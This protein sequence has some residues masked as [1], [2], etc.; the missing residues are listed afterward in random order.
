[1]DGFVAA[2]VI[3]RHT[4]EPYHHTMYRLNRSTRISP[5]DKSP[6]ELCASDSRRP[7]SQPRYSSF[8]FAARTTRDFMT[9]FLHT[10]PI[11]H[12][13]PRTHRAVS[14]TYP[15]SY[16]ILFTG[17]CTGR[18]SLPREFNL[19]RRYFRMVRGG[20]GAGYKLDELRSRLTPPFPHPSAKLVEFSAIL[21]PGNLNSVPRRYLPSTRD[22]L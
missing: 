2:I 9:E 5:S 1:M 19:P 7:P 20:S 4:D 22:L 16:R 8:V 3:T 13:R 14:H 21:P 18:N 15:I 6:D 17:A 11:Y 12:G 10:S